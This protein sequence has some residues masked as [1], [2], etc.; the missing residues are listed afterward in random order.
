MQSIAETDLVV[1]GGGPAG[2]AAAITARSYGLRVILLERDAAA[3]VR[4][5]EAAHPGIEPLLIRLGVI[6]AVQEANFLRYEGHWVSWGGKQLHFMHFGRDEEGAWKGFQLWRPNFDE[7]LLNGA[8]RA[9]A[10]IIRP[11]GEV[12]PIVKDNRVTCVETSLGSWRCAFAIDATGRQRWLARAL[13]LEIEH[14]GPKQVAWFNY[15]E[16]ECPFLDQMNPMIASDA[17][18]WTWM[19]R[20]QPNIY[21]WVR[22]PLNGAR[23]PNGWCP[24]EFDGLRSMGPRRGIDV[25]SS[26]ANPT[27]GPGYFLAGDAASIVDPLSSH[28]ILKALMSGMKA[29]HH[30]AT[31]LRHGASPPAIASAY[32]LWLARWFRQD[33]SG[34]GELYHAI[35]G[36]KRAALV[37]RRRINPAHSL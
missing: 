29:A 11:C 19:A 31:V 1:V 33:R 21:Q 16:G 30:S 27:A 35:S 7:I 5:G 36:P 3:R 9:G 23:P 15:A 2:A 17:S 34:L 10:T 22:L 20:V 26:I 6:A 25:S 18:G 32:H 37:P 13:N 12:R 8:N 28:G 4:P 24:V 14:H